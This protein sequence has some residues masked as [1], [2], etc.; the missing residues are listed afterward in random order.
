M[1]L[2]AG[3]ELNAGKAI[4]GNL[5]YLMAFACLIARAICR[6]VDAIRGDRERAELKPI[7]NRPTREV[8][9]GS[10]LFGLRITALVF[11]IAGAV[12]LFGGTIYW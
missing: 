10:A 2:E 5:L 9:I 7:M 12:L 1:M 6:L 8:D 11:E 4:A 3:Q